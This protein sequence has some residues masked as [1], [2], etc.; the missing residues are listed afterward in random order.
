[1]L[2]TSLYYIMFGA[3]SSFILIPVVHCIVFKLTIG[4]FVFFLKLGGRIIRVDHCSNYRRPLSDEKDEHG[5]RK[6][7]IEEGCAPK[8]PSPSPPASE[9]EEILE[10]PKKRKKE[11]KAKKDK[12]LKE[13]KLQKRKKMFSGLGQK[14]LEELTIKKNRSVLGS[15]NK[16]EGNDRDLSCDRDLQN[17]KASVVHNSGRDRD[18]RDHHTNKQ[19]RDSNKH[20]RD[21][22]IRD[23]KREREINESD[24]KARNR[25]Q[26]IRERDREAHT[27]QFR[28]NYIT[29]NRKEQRDRDYH[30]SSRDNR[31]HEVDERKRDRFNRPGDH[32]DESRNYERR[33]RNNF[34]D[35]RDRR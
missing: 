29:S 34:S 24:R 15:D 14:D 4:L 33:D 16:R 3:C 13:E 6:E 23:R 5:K 22:H 17:V 32:R 1:M 28:D 11:K 31:G 27:H 30:Y 12:K 35:R 18:F 9:D 10:L 19:G 20:V 8:T 2:F 7:I 25:E 21:G 26:Y